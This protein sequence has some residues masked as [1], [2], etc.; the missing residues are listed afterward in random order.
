MESIDRLNEK[1][2]GITLLKG[3]EV[4]ILEDGKLALPDDVLMELD[5]VI[6]AVHSHFD[7][8]EPKQTARVLRAMEH[9]AFTIL[10][11]PL[12]RLLGERPAVKLN[13]ER[14]CRA[15]KSRPCFLELDA[16][17]QRLDLDEVHCRMA[18]EHGVLV[19]IASDAHSGAQFENLDYG[20]I[21]ARR[22]W[23]TAADVLNSRRLSELRPLLRSTFL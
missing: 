18:R 4:D 11:H 20:V 7:L 10:S 6:G 16:Q 8:S 23:L 14:V 22:G 12:T 21:Q 2:D 13:L 17:P 1:L 3:A 5:V 15:A 19:S 9:R